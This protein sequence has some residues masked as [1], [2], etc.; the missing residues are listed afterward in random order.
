VVILGRGEDGDGEEPETADAVIIATG[1][2]VKTLALES[3]ADW[4]QPVRAVPIFTNKPLALIVG[5]DLVA[6]AA[7]QSIFLLALSHFCTNGLGGQT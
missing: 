3:E 1:A 5:G 2:R 4:D 7:C 6:E